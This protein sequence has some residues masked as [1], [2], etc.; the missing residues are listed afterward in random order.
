MRA[1]CMR[2]QHQVV[3]LEFPK[4]GR[5]GGYRVSSRIEVRHFVFAARVAG[6]TSRETRILIAYGDRGFRDKRA[7]LVRDHSSNASKGCLRASGRNKKRRQRS[8][9]AAPCR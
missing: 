6:H 8:A 4:P 2:L 5:F 9:P 3:M 7:A 1:V